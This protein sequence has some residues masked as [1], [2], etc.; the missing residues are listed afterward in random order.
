[1]AIVGSKQFQEIQDPADMAGK[2]RA[3]AKS[4]T[5]APSYDS[6]FVTIT[7]LIVPTLDQASIKERVSSCRGNR[8]FLWIDDSIACANPRYF[9]RQM[10][11]KSALTRLTTTPEKAHKSCELHDMTAR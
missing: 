1:M 6:L 10:E 3:E 2:V 8:T 5:F 11:T 9:R 7:H 4:L